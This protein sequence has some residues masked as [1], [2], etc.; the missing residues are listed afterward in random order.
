[1]KR[2]NSSFLIF[3]F[4]ILSS[5]LAFISIVLNNKDTI[6]WL[7]AMLPISFPVIILINYGIFSKIKDRLS[8]LLIIVCYYMRMVILPVVFVYSN[9]SSL[10]VDNGYLQ[11]I[12]YACFLAIYEFLIVLS[13]LSFFDNKKL[14]KNIKERETIDEYNKNS[15]KLFNYIVIILLITVIVGFIVY[16]QFKYNFR[17]IFESNI[18]NINLNNINHKIMKDS[19]PPVIYWLIIYIIDILQVLLP[20]VII[21]SIK[22]MR[23]GNNFK[24]FLSLIVISI[25]ILI[26]TPETARS[27]IIALSLC[28]ILIKLYPKQKRLLISIIGFV[29]VPAVFYGLITKSRINASMNE[30]SNILNAYFSGI[31]NIATSFLIPNRP[32][33][34]LFFIDIINSI[35]FISVLFKETMSTTTLFNNVLYNNVGRHDQIIPMVSQSMCYFGVIFGPMLSYFSAKMALK[36]EKDYYEEN[37]IYKKYLKL[38]FTIYFA[39]SPIVYNFSILVSTVFK[40][41]IP[42]ILITNFKL[43]KKANK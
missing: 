30:V 35:P 38:L 28:I 22:K 36:I 5:F 43:S 27:I 4:I 15:S 23:L 3:M 8:I 7:I 2:N 32:N 42:C 39:I 20:I 9:Y 34:S 40:I 10:I 33:I 6:Y 1:M 12:T 37:N 18:N 29:L 21:N 11:Y 19:I 26:C 13:L 16:P 41:I 14:V 25:I 31:S 24:F 17:F